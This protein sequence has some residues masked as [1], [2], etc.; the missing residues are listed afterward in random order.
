VSAVLVGLPFPTLHECESED[1]GSDE[2]QIISVDNGG[3]ESQ[4]VVSAHRYYGSS[5]E[6]QDKVMI[7]A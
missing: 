5:R 3:R 4:R 1:P 6:R 2:L 7:E